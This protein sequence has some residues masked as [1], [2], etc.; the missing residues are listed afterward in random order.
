VHTGATPSRPVGVWKVIAPWGCRIRKPRSRNFPS[1]LLAPTT[2]GSV[3]IPGGAATIHW[4]AKEVL[5]MG[6]RPRSRSRQTVINN[7]EAMQSILERKGE[8]LI[9]EFVLG[10]YQTVTENIPN[11]VVIGR[12]RETDDVGV[13][14]PVT[15]TV[16]HTPPDHAKISGMI[17]ESCQ[18]ANVR[19]WKPFG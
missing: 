10:I 14:D 6:I 19:A 3:S 13:T 2:S 11:S 9:P 4:T 18:F 8:T 17:E 16:Y 5:R 15:G 1:N 7:Y 12:F